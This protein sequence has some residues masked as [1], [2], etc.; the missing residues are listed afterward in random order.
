[1]FRY[2][3]DIKAIGWGE[4]PKHMY[5]GRL[6]GNR[7]YYSKVC[8]IARRRRLPGRELTEDD[9]SYNNLM[10]KMRFLTEQKNA[11]TKVFTCLSNSYHRSMKALSDTVKMVCSIKPYE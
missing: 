8:G 5:S 9:K 7:S 3:N 6:I 4:L 1:M 11:S 2:I 10:N